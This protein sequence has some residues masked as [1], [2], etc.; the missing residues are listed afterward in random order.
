MGCQLFLYHIKLKVVVTYKIQKGEKLR[1]YVKGYKKS[2]KVK[3][4]SSNKKIAS[5]SKSGVVT[6]KKGGTCKITAKIGKK[7][8]KAKIFVLAGERIVYKHNASSKSPSNRHNSVFVTLNIN[9]KNLY[10]GQSIILKVSGTKRKITWKSSNSKVAT[11]SSKGYVVSKGE[12]QAVITASY[13]DSKYIYELDCKITVNPLW[14]TEKALEAKGLFFIKMSDSVIHIIGQS[15][16]I[17]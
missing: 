17:A 4:K 10:I 2:K 8:Y 7:R 11:V 5:I 13:K 9:E 15:K 6:G 3:W 12:G 16:K 1:L 14:M